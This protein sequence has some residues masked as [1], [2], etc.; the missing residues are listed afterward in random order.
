MYN[1]VHPE[2]KSAWNINSGA[3]EIDCDHSN[4]E[5]CQDGV[6]VNSFMHPKANKA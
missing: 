5:T 2:E 1:T 3:D 4:N 6:Y